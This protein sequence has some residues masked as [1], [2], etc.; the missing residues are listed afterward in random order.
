M[1]DINVVKERVIEELKKAGYR[2]VLHR[3]LC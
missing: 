2:C 1:T 3:L